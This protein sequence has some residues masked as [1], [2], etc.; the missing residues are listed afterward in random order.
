[1]KREAWTPKNPRI[2]LSR[3]P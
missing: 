1:M 3:C 2:I